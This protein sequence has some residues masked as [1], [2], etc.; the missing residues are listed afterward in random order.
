[1]AAK[2]CHITDCSEKLLILMYE[3]STNSTNFP[4]LLLSRYG[5]IQ[6]YQTF[7]WFTIKV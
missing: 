2:E 4:A 5:F 6:F 1:M 7:H 3:I